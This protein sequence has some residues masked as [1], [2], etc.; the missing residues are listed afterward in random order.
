MRDKRGILLTVI[1]H[2]VIVVIIVIFG[3][4]TP[5]PLPDEEGILINF[6]TEET[7]SGNIEPRISDIPE[8]PQTESPVNEVVEETEISTQDF[9]EAPVIEEEQTIEKEPVEENK[10]IVP[11]QVEEESNEPDTTPGSGSKLEERDQW[12]SAVLLYRYL[13]GALAA[14]LC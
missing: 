12:Y 10:D 8:Q 6:G 9:E 14:P 7:G 2:G 1:I 5:L 3:F 13:W 4:T 11:E